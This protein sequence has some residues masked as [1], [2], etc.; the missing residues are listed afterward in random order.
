MSLKSD[1]YWTMAKRYQKA[2]GTEINLPEA[3]KLAA[4]AAEFY[5]KWAKAARQ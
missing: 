5:D 3:E 2:A 4:K 1:T